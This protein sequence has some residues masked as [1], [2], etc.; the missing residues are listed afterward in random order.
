MH[1]KPA[2]DMELKILIVEDVPSTIKL[3]S[4]T[5]HSLGQVFV[6]KDGELALSIVQREIPDLILLD[7]QMPNMNG[8]EVCKEIKKHPDYAHICIIFVTADSHPETEI[9]ALD[10]GGIDFITKPIHPGILRTRVQT[11]LTAI[12]RTRQLVHATSEL[13]RLMSTLPVFVSYWSNELVNI[14]SNDSE[15]LWF[16]LNANELKDLFLSTLFSHDE[17]AQILPN[18]QS[19]LKGR[20]SIAELAFEP[21][22]GRRQ[23]AQLSFIA[24]KPFSGVDGFI[25]VI[26]DITDR[27]SEEIRLKE[28]K[29][30]FDVTLQSIGDGVI[31]TD[32][33]GK[34]TFI[35]PIA[36]NLL[37]CVAKD[38]VG[39]PIENVMNIKDAYTGDTLTNPIRLALRERTVVQMP[40]DTQLIKA[41]G[42]ILDIEDSAAPI[43]NNEGD[44][45]GAIIVFHDVTEAKVASAKMVRLATLD[46]LTA[47]PNRLLLLDRTQQEINKCQRDKSK[48][49][50]L[51]IDLDGFESINNKHGYLAGDN[52]LIEIGNKL[53]RFVSEGDTVCRPGGDEFV[54]LLTDIFDGAY[55]KEYCKSLLSFFTENWVLDEKTFNLTASIGVAIYPLDGEDAP[56]LYRRADT[57]M[58]E[59]KRKGRNSYRFYSKFL[60]EELQK[61]FQNEVALRDAI[62]N[63]EIE[64][65]YQPKVCGNTGKYVGAEALVRW[66]RPNEDGS[67]T[68][69]F[70]DH[71]IPL[72]EKTKLIIPM[73]D[74]VLD[75]ACAQLAK[76]QKIAPKMSV[77]VNISAIQF[78]PSLAKSVESC[79]SRYDIEAQYLE[80]EI[81]ESVLI[82]DEAAIDTVSQLKAL[83]IKLCLDDFGK[84]FSSLSY[85]RAFPLDVLKI[86]QSFVFKMLDDDTDLGIC[87]TIISLAKKLNLSVVAE[88]VETQAHA[89][90]LLEMNCSY[91]QGYLYSKPVQ[92]SIITQTLSAQ[93]HI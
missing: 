58:R 9:A 62:E 79:L 66:N 56:S 41:D 80:L 55:V 81:T 8:I 82:N 48:C 77:S 12:K 59:C 30:R 24:E 83:G 17:Y 78:T 42:D 38:S 25:I 69:V 90:R 1:Q 73:G 37:G 84:G 33:T 32:L 6:A 85:I 91:F 10:M 4:E 87:E 71:F 53:Q 64:V 15:G 50:L 13:A 5:I 26:T 86:D 18:I 70:P 27:K 51:M 65:Y 45:I 34:V 21:N 40:L 2:P 11:Q 76:W 28:D 68:L 19:V 72:A 20:N 54:I 63:D 74:K 39:L 60:E 35:N 14:Y 57:A 47:L 49:C 93:Y 75:A 29:D 46:N 44:V 23:Y 16:G 36:E 67:S 52:L 61:E 43:T 89:E 3:V 92:A 31:A 22:K 88:G 7:I